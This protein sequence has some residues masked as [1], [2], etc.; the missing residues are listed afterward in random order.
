MPAYGPR[1]VGSR[2]SIICM[3]RIFGAP[4][5][6]PA[7]KH[8]F[9]TSYASRLSSNSPRTFET[10][11]M[12]WEYFSMTIS[13]FTATRPGFDTLPT[14]FRPRSTSIICSARSLGSA[15]SSFIRDSS[16]SSLAPLFL[17]PAMGRRSM[18]EPSSRTITSGDEP[19]R[20]NPPQFK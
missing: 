7:G 2:S 14:S 9:I 6:V 13:S 12:T 11:C 3:A 16:S 10:M 18:R 20:T 15:R 17:V 19:V 8:A 1:L 5:T 4:E